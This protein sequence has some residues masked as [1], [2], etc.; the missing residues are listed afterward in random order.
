MASSLGVNRIWCG[1]M[2]YYVCCGLRE[3]RNSLGSMHPSCECTRWSHRV[4]T[5]GTSWARALRITLP[6]T[7]DR[8]SLRGVLNVRSSSVTLMTMVIAACLICRNLPK[9]RDWLVVRLII[10]IAPYTP[11]GGSVSG[12]VPRDMTVGRLSR[13][14]FSE[15]CRSSQCGTLLQCLQ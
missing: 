12:R 3:W 7:S 14:G 11:L 8:D 9:W 4:G 13:H 10:I 2:Q 5:M 15:L 1:G 6:H